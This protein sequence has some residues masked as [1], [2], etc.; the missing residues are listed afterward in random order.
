M[1]EIF[2]D[3]TIALKPV[4]N[5]FST[6]FNFSFIIILPWHC[7][8]YVVDRV[9]LNK[10]WKKQLKQ[11]ENTKCYIFIHEHINFW[12]YWHCQTQKKKKKKSVISNKNS[13]HIYTSLTH[14]MRSRISQSETTAVLCSDG[15]VRWKQNLD[16]RFIFSAF[17]SCHPTYSQSNTT[18]SMT[19]H[20]I[21]SINF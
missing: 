2:Q 13:M 15:S 14:I 20:S 4:M 6:L 5:A 21:S 12:N 9:S 1:N 17:T 11:I 19:C 16:L 18:W 7:V 3:L 10:P 8:T